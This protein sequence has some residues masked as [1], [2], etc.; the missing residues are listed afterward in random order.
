MQAAPV[1]VLATSAG[2]RHEGKCELLSSLAGVSSQQCGVKPAHPTAQV[3]SHY[4]VCW[5]C[6]M[7]MPMYMHRPFLAHLPLLKS[8]RTLPLE[9]AW[10]VWHGR[11]HAPAEVL[12]KDCLHASPSLQQQHISFGGVLSVLPTRLLHVVHI[13]TCE[14]H[15]HSCKQYAALMETFHSLCKLACSRYS[16]SKH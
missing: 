4:I 13:T 11:L 3:G 5:P 7:Q 6:M 16:A 12:V 2:T 8:P 9:A 1:P 10:E 15:W 14:A